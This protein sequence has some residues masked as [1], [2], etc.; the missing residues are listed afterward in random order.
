MLTL[1]CALALGM[2]LTQVESGEGC[3]WHLTALPVLVKRVLGY[4]GLPDAVYTRLV[5]NSGY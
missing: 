4:L 5:I 1:K 3:H 2:T